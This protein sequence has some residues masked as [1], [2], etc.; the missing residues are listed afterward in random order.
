MSLR[1]SLT[2][3]AI[4]VLVATGFVAGHLTAQQVHMVNALDHLKAAKAELEAASP[5]K[6]GH[7]AKAIQLT[8]DAIH[9]TELGIGVGASHGD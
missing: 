9:Q 6:G 5:D 1:R 2:Y 3:L 7:R 4:V 8:K